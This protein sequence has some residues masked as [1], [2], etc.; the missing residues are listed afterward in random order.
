MNGLGFLIYLPK[1][2]PTAE[3]LIADLQKV[4]ARWVSFKVS[5]GPRIY[6][7]GITEL[8]QALKAAGISVGGWSYVYPDGGKGQADRISE[9]I[10]TL[11]LDH[12]MLD[13]EKEWKHLALQG[14]IDTLLNGI[15]IGSNYPLGFCS[16]RYPN[17]HPPIDYGRFL[18]HAKMQFNAPQVYW[19]GSHD[20]AVQ[21]LASYHQYQ[22][23][24]AQPFIPIGSTFSW[25]EWLPSVNDLR[26]FISVCTEMACPAYG[27]YS[28]DFIYR[29]QHTDWL[30]AIAGW[31]PQPQ[32]EIPATV[33]V[34]VNARLRNAPSLDD[35]TKMGV[36]YS[37]VDID[38]TGMDGDFY[39]VQGYIH[40]SMIL[41]R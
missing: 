14:Q 37:G 10:E 21:T 35:S 24:P 31:K 3:M 41:K 16:Y 38:V 7:A 27:F 36:V 12:L 25:G 2:L 6:N 29:Y 40:K 8:V 1:Y 9:R 39:A 30:D 33:R 19:L 22:K 17:L 28:L 5:D 11:Q 4:N 20:P 34:R 32:P 15:K 23:Y 13:V 18:G 26:E